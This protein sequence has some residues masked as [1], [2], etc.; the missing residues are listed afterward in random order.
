MKQNCL[1]FAQSKQNSNTMMLPA[2]PTVAS[3]TINKQ[4][5]SVKLPA[6]TR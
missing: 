1:N 2:T 6:D 4:E 5:I 3:F